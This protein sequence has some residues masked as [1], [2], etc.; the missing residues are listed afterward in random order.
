MVM[1][2]SDSLY[3][4][5]MVRALPHDGNRY[6]VVWGE[7]LVTPSPALRHQR[8]VGRLYVDLVLY[9]RTVPA[10][11]VMS[12]PADI[13]WSDDTLVQPDVFVIAPEDAGAA[14]WTSV[15]RLSLVAEVLSPST[16]RQDRLIKR[17]LYQEQ[18]IETIWLIDGERNEVEVWTP[19]QRFPELARDELAWQPLA[20]HPPLRI[21]LGALFAP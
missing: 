12:S 13:S 4:A 14:T 6:E 16:R 15:Q 10:G 18:G 20:S 5:D 11:E 1:P 9:C 8:L 3:T 17:R 2:L 19:A 21:P 7:L